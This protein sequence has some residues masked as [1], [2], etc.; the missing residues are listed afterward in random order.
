M[1]N[2]TPT[3]SFDDVYQ[4]EITDPIEGGA[5]G[6]D[7]QPHQQL[8]NRTEYLKDR[9]D[10][11]LER[12]AQARSN[13]VL[14]GQYDGATGDYNALSAPASNTLR[15][16]AS[17]SF[18]FIYSASGGYDEYGEVTDVRKVTANLELSTASLPNRTFL[19][20]VQHS[21]AGNPELYFC[22]EDLYYATPY[23]P[24]EPVSDTA[25]WFNTAIG[26][27]FVSASGAGW[28]EWRTVVVGRFT[29]SGGS[30]TAVETFP[31]RQSYYD[32]ETAGGTMKAFAANKTPIGGWLF[33]NGG[34]VSRLRYRNLFNAIGTTY[35]VGDG[36][37]T[38]NLPDMRGYF[39]R[40]HDTGGAVD[41][42]RAFGSTQDD[43]FEAHNHTFTDFAAN[44]QTQVLADTG[45]AGGNVSLP[46][47]GT[48][49]ATNSV[50]NNTGGTE[51]RPKNVAMGMWIKF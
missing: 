48:A 30:I 44:I 41:A 4:F 15:L 23:E 47:A 36:S 10:L 45:G 46:N 33:C 14:T 32:E 21:G 13:V 28:Q 6:I 19:A 51:T 39:L 7:N 24:L 22:Q 31:Y 20:L 43:A 16:T 35:G 25:L 40:G 8:L 49:Y 42:G 27:S 11:G 17:V 1:A 18:P 3:S 9:L 37:T 5:G 2:L 12:N 34:A 50:M 26:K 38:F 29:K